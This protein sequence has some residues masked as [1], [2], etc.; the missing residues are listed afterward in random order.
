MVMKFGIA[1]LVLGIVAF[2]VY[3]FTSRPDY[4]LAWEMDQSSLR[5]RV[6]S[7]EIYPKTAY[8][9]NTL[10]IRMARATPDEYGYL[11]VR[12]FRNGQEIPGV[13]GPKLAPRHFH[14]GD[15]IYAEINLLGPEKMDE[16]VRTMPVKI[17][18]SPPRIV[19][20]ST[21][22]R[23]LE[24]DVLFARVNAVDPDG[25]R[26]RYH[27]TWYRNGVEIPDANKPVLPVGDFG[28]GDQIWA[29]ITATDGDIETMPYKCDPITLG[30]DLPVITSQ[31]PSSL[32]PD[33]RYVY[34]LEVSVP[35]PSTLTYELVEAPEGMTISSTGMIDWEVP[36]AQA[37]TRSYEVVVR[38]ANA[39]GDEAFQKFT[40]DLRGRAAD[41]DTP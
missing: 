36:P 37:G 8:T 40:I 17:L 10:Q 19:S 18:N 5:A 29:V 24:S 41:A 9:N 28:Q 23:T 1:M 6:A 4:E 27:Y 22:L 32:T 3:S 25:D 30:S 2:G 34:Q 26:L 13:A 7:A 15:E 38:V 12:W 14:R 39:A 33:R 35:D 11:D 31:P 20:A 16:P 21:A